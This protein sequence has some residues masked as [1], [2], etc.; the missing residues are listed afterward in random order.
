MEDLFTYLVLVNIW[1]DIILLELYARQPIF[2]LGNK[3][4]TSALS[5][6]NSHWVFT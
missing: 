6:E 3:Y 2:D 1:L 5:M 4:C